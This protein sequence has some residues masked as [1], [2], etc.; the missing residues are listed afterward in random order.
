MEPEKQNRVVAGVALVIAGLI[1]L[2]FGKDV[3]RRGLK[4]AVLSVSF[5]SIGGGYYLLV[6][7]LSKE[8]TKQVDG[9]Q[10]QYS[11]ASPEEFRAKLDKYKSRKADTQGKN[12]RRL[13]FACADG[14]EEFTVYL[15]AAGSWNVPESEVTCKDGSKLVSYV[16]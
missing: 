5:L 4:L 12:V 14:S 7:G 8:A 13:N 9:L 2:I 1:G 3:K 11:F 16:Q 10:G 15:T 6:S